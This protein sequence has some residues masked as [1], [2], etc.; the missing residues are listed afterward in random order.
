MTGRI[1]LVVLGL[2]G[3]GSAGCLVNGQ[4]VVNPPPTEKKTQD[5]LLEQIIK[6]DTLT[7]QPGSATLKADPVIKEIPLKSSLTK[8]RS[9]MEGHGFT[10]WGGVPDDG[11]VCMRC[12][13]YYRKTPRLADK[14]MVKLFYEKNEVVSI[15]ILIEYAVYR[16]E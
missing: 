6:Q 9:I 4:N 13:A 1:L 12:T 7:K 16:P 15:E 11:R 14:V 5:P 3:L 8:A 10:C 2:L